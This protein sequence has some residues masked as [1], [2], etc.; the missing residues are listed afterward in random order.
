MIHEEIILA[1]HATYVR[2]PRGTGSVSKL[3]VDESDDLTY[4]RPHS[5]LGTQ[6]HIFKLVVD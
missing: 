1:S 5:S 6:L 3:R 4:F 2:S